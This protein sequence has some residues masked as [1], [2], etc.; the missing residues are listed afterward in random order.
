MAIQRDKS[1]LGTIAPYFI[2]VITSVI[3]TYAAVYGSVLSAK[4][5]EM[6]I[7]YERVKFL[8]ERDAEKSRIIFEQGANISS[9][10]I[11]LSK[12]YERSDVLKKYL[13]SFPYP[14]WIKKVELNADQP[15]FPRFVMWHINEA[16]ER[17]YK[18]SREYYVG[19][20]DVNVFG[21]AAK[22]F[23]K[24]D[25]LTLNRMAPRCV[26]E[27]VPENIDS[28]VTNPEYV[29]KWVIDLEDGIAVAGMALKTP[30]VPAAQ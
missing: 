19:K 20:I 29:C 15:E 6:R 17:R 28:D 21:T 14:A 9:L 26:F 23:Y 25:L 2:T 7:L 5:D 18:V 4:S 24:N 12:K 13:D 10:T 27:P 22:E 30:P 16:Y 11:E 8:E 3:T 1:A